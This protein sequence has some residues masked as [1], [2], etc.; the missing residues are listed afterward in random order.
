MPN[1]DRLP[2]AQP[3]RQQGSVMNSIN[4]RRLIP[5][6]KRS[7]S[8]NMGHVRVNWAWSFWS[9]AKAI[10]TAQCWRLLNKSVKSDDSRNQWNL[11]CSQ[12]LRQASTHLINTIG[13]PW[14]KEGRVLGRLSCA[15]CGQWERIFTDYRN[16]I[17]DHK[18]ITKWNFDVSRHG[19]HYVLTIHC[20][21]QHRYSITPPTT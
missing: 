21:S 13:F 20:C 11:V 9:R 12:R 5:T 1:N 8:R 16:T 4:Y 14:I 7:T 3:Q 2:K 10:S 19:V 18:A 15:F 17:D 6:N